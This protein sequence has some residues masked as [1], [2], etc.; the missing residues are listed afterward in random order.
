MVITDTVVHEV[1]IARWLLGEE[2]VRATVHAGRASGRTAAGLRDPQLVVLETEAGVLVEVE[3]FVN[4]G[5]GYD[6]GCEV[7]AEAGTLALAPAA[8]VV[9]RRGGEAAAPVPAGYQERFAAAYV[10]ELQDWVAGIDGGPSAWDGYAACA[11]TEA[12]VASL[13]GGGPVDVRLRE[14]PPLYAGDL[15]PAG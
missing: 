7:V 3:A 12:C 5:Y 14:R 13:H 1:D 8:S 10:R 6:I 15:A 2:V 4:A 9:E 11:V